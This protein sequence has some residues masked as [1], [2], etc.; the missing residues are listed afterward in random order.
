[1][2]V[3]LE[4]GGRRREVVESEGRG[5]VV[6]ERCSLL[7]RRVWGFVVR[8]RCSLLSRR[9]WGSLLSHRIECSMSR[10]RI[11]NCSGFYGDRLSAM[12]EML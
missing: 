4:L 7:S 9:V 3:L 5:F 11:G 1:M 8:E 12:R 10:I 6:R 2:L